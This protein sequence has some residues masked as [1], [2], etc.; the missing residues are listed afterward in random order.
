MYE[1]PYTNICLESI[2]RVSIFVIGGIGHYYYR[3]IDRHYHVC[4]YAYLLR[5]I[6]GKKCF[7]F[8]LIKIII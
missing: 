8:G 3:W 7:D 4:V 6:V 2:K 1:Q 5:L